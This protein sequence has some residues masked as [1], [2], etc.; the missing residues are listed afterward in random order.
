MT[1]KRVKLSEALKRKGKT[2]ES[3]K[4]MTDKEIIRRAELDPDNPILSDEEI[5]QLKP[6]KEK[7][8]SDD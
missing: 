7:E 4:N 3:V 5:E 1:I 2:K 8:K 6:V